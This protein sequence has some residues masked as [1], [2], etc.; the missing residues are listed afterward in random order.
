MTTAKAHGLVQDMP[1][2]LA[3]SFFSVHRL[4]AHV[5]VA[6]CVPTRPGKV[7]GGSGSAMRTFGLKTVL[8]LGWNPH[9]GRVSL[10]SGRYRIQDS[11]A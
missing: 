8:R 5:C 1:A 2:S 6:H 11:L 4:I 3:D 10:A 7:G 9:R